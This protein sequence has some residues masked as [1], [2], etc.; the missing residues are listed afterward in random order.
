[1]R[2]PSRVLLD[3]VFPGVALTRE[4]GEHETLLSIDHA[5]E[6]LGFEPLHSWRTELEE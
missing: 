4:I 5:R 1:M 2:T 3:E 6:H